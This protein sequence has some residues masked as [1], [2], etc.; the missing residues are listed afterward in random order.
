[1]LNK[2]RE[3]KELY[4]AK[5]KHDTT[6]DDGHDYEKDLLERTMSPVMFSNP[7][8][9]EFLLD[10]KRIMITMIDSTAQVRNSLNYLVDKYHNRHRS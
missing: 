1:M 7:K 5:H 3:I 6:D 8:M 9:R 4:Y 10:V 2:E